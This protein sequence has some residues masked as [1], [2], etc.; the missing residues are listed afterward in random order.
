MPVT[1][2]FPLSFSNFPFFKVFPSIAIYS[3]LRLIWN[4]DH[5]LFGKLVSVQIKHFSVYYNNTVILT[6]L[7]IPYV[8]TFYV[9]H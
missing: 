1:Y 5:S 2:R 7:L 4:Y 8:F 6:Y 9:S 3:F